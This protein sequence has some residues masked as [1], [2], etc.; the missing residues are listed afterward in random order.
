[1]RHPGHQHDYLFRE[2]VG[3]LLS[4][5]WE[6]PEARAVAQTLA[7]YV[8]EQPNGTGVELIKPLLPEILSN[9]YAVAWPVLGDAIVSDKAKAWLLEH[10]LGDNFSF[11]REKRPPVLKVPEEV[12]LSWCHRYPDTAPAFLAAVVPFLTSLRAE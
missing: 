9:F 5:G 8:A 4:K 10:V 1:R 12:L 3:W 11:E 2:I 6:D 7:K